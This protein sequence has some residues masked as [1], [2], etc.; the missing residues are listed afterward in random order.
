MG[1]SWELRVRGRISARRRHFS[2]GLRCLAER[3][4][5]VAV[6]FSPRKTGEWM[7]SRS[8]A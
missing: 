6:G 7:A 4:L 3:D 8:D 1:D 5:K 2:N